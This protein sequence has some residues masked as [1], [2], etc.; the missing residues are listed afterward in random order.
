MADIPADHPAVKVSRKV[1]AT[2]PLLAA[3]GLTPPVK[4]A[5]KTLP[6]KTKYRTLEQEILQDDLY[7]NGKM[8]AVEVEAYDEAKVN[9]NPIVRKFGYAA[10]TNSPTKIFLNY[11]DDE[12]GN[13]KYDNIYVT[14]YHESRH[15]VQ[16]VSNLRKPP[17]TFM[18]MLFFEVNAYGD[19]ALWINKAKTKEM[20]IK[21]S[22]YTDPEKEYAE[23]VKSTD[24]ANNQTIE[25]AQKSAARIIFAKSEPGISQTVGVTTPSKF[26]L[27]APSNVSHEA[28]YFENMRL[29]NYLPKFRS[30][31]TREY[32][33]GD[34]YKQTSNK[35][36]W[37]PFG[38]TTA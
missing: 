35:N 22:Q 8:N 26:E 27:P 3:P 13:P 25:V 10:W 28:I 23:L 19:T 2:G 15:I 17:H 37:A 24:E 16:F 1:L 38:Y 36:Y 31:A 21:Y 7:S 9:L 32:K 12:H 33:I 18:Q 34:L 11:S 20:L 29:N 5:P 6:Q 30:T 4:G 14:L